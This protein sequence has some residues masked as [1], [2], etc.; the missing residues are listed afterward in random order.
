MNFEFNIIM[1]VFACFCAFIFAYLF[2]WIF[3]VF[4]NDRKLRSS[5]KKSSGINNKLNVVDFCC[6]GFAR[7]VLYDMLKIN[8]K[9]SN[10]QSRTWIEKQ[11]FKTNEL[12]NKIKELCIKS[13]FHKSFGKFALRQSQL[14]YSILF[15]CVGCII[16]FIFSNLLMIILLFVGFLLGWYLPIWALKKERE[17]RLANLEKNLP[18]MIDVIALGMRSGLTFD[19][20]LDV[21]S[22][23]FDNELSHNCSKAKIKWDASICSRDDA[24]RD[25]ARTYDSYLFK[26]LVENIIRSLRFG[27]SLVENLE[28]SAQESR[29]LYKEKQEEI[30]SKAPVKMML[31]TGTLILPAMLIFVLGPVI[32]ELI[33]GF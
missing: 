33:S 24:L 13:N 12:S 27:S 6:S 28:Q 3:I 16:G 11:L 22:S 8:Y 5:I 20:A 32:L 19:R 9:V 23:Y 29:N 21:Y 31:P 1:L 25:M 17:A 7:T 10:L 18:E 4:S 15:S 2:T 26:R 14:K 30:V